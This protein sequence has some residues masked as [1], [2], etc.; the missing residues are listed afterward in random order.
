MVT[1]I[2][3]TLMCIDCLHEWDITQYMYEDFVICP[4]CKCKN[5]IG[6]KIVTSC[7]GTVVASSSELEV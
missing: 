5:E 7:C 1:T 3:R 2:S 6:V 4:E